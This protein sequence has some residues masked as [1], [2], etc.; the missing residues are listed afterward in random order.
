MERGL[1][2]NVVVGHRSFIFQLFSGV[3][4]PLLVG[5]NALLV[6]DFGFQCADGVG[7]LYFKRDCFSGECLYE[8]LHCYCYV[9][10]IVI[11]IV[12]VML[13]DIIYSL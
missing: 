10:V 2:L 5:W 3:N 1:F 4:E 8:N 13:C 12:I 9:I 11:V 6:L 7:G